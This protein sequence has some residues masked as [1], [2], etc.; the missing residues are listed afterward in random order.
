MSTIV[1]NYISSEYGSIKITDEI[2]GGTLTLVGTAET[3]LFEDDV[4]YMIELLND[5]EE[6]KSD[7]KLNITLLGTSEITGVYYGFT[8]PTSM[9]MSNF[10]TDKKG[11]IGLFQ[12]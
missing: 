12:L 10:V 8:L 4:N 3:N 9:V 1:L 7:G 2:N 6:Q 5:L 11:I